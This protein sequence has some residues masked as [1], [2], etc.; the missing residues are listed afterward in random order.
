MRIFVRLLAGVLALTAVSGALAGEKPRHVV[1]VVWD[2]M[3][4]DFVGA[5]TTPNLFRLAQQGVTFKNHH[6]VYITTTEVNGTALA[7]GMYPGESGVIGNKE[8]RPAIQPAKSIHTEDLEAIRKGDGLWDKRYLAFPT[9]AEMLHE[10]GLTTV[11]A[12]AKP[13]ALLHD[14]APRAEQN[15]GVNLFAGESLPESLAPELRRQFGDFPEANISSVERDDWTA[16]ALLGRLWEKGVPAFTVLWLSEPD[17]SQHETGP[18]SA[19]SLAAIR[20]SDQVL[21]RVLAALDGKHVRE[22]TDVIVV[23]DHA[24]STIGRNAD[25]AATLN[26][27]GFNAFRKFP[28]EG[29]RDGDIL[30]IGNGGTVFLYV[31]GSD[32]ALVERITRCLQ[33]QDFA[34]VLFTREGL[35]GTFSLKDGRL[36]SK[37]APDIVMS[38]RWSPAKS[39]NGTPGLIC[40][41]YSEYGPGQGM[42]GSL[43][44]YDLH[45]FCV[46]AGPDFREGILDYVPSGNIDI[47][48]TIL[49]ILGVTPPHKLSGRVLREAM[50]GSGPVNVAFESKRLDATYRGGDFVWRQYLNYSEV[51]GTVYFDEGNG[52][53]AAPDDV[54]RVAPPA[55]PVRQ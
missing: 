29:A 27:N 28:A 36:H 25:V 39:T 43:S 1:L 51:N 53:Q 15:L 55:A 19:R 46:A 35:P 54:A 5:E 47:A 37:F 13:V 24:F 7:T 3:R 17:H 10:H 11:I 16:E 34:G 4:P 31:Q 23:S 44:T 48:P 8:F 9:V 18:G 6:P 14:R 41:D 30:V 38:L 40:S 20:H 52:E 50:S 21:A 2:G 26:R 32:A 33:R 42:H 45:N 49:A 22:T 12:G